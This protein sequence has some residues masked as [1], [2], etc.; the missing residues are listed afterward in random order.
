ME[1]IRIENKKTGIR[2]YTKDNKYRIWKPYKKACWELCEI[3]GH[4]HKT[5]T[6]SKYFKDVR[7]YL[8]EMIG[9]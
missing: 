6:Y 7:K 2:Y 5:I 9:E 4:G 1:L 8:K 3:T